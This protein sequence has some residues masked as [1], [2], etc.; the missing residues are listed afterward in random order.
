MALVIAP[1]FENALVLLEDVRHLFVQYFTLRDL[2]NLCETYETWLL[3]AE[4]AQLCGL[5]DTMDSFFDICEFDSLRFLRWCQENEILMRR[6]VI[7]VSRSTNSLDL[8]IALE[9]YLKKFGSQVIAVS[10]KFTF[11]CESA[12]SLISLAFR[13]CPN[14]I[15]FSLDGGLLHIPADQCWTILQEAR[16]CHSL[17]DWVFVGHN[18]L[19]TSRAT[20]AYVFFFET[21]QHLHRFDREITD[22]FISR[23]QQTIQACQYTLETLEAVKSN[24]LFRITFINSDMSDFLHRCFLSMAENLHL[25]YGISSLRV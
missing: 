11:N 15:M 24:K 2:W 23:R 22:L 20:Y 18:P 14:L 13:H 3:D 19:T 10:F 12:T 21:L 4:F 8:L 25:T 6:L 17:Y 1:T 7:H 9:S 16:R 5:H